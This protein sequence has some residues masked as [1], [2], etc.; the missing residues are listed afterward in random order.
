MLRDYLNNEFKTVDATFRAHADLITGVAVQK[1][2]N[3]LTAFPAEA[4]ADN[5]F[6]VDMAPVPY[7]TLTAY[8]N[9]SD[10]QFENVPANA[11]VKLVKYYAG[12]EFLTNGAALDAA[13]AGKVVA[14]GADGKLVVATAASRYQYLGNVDDNGHVLARIRVLD[15][16]ITNA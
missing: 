7:G 6:F 16:P 3:G 5:L 15:A 4:T 2:D 1:G 12:E 9:I 10:Y 14:A 11:F 13:D 8:T